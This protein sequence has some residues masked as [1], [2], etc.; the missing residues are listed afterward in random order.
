MQ[1]ASRLEALVL[2]MPRF[3]VGAAI[4]FSIALNL[5]NIIGRY[6]FRAPILWAEEVLVYLMVWSV[7]V[8]A[9]LVTWEGRHLKMD[10]LS[11]RIPP[12]F[13]GVVG[14]IG[15]AIFVAVCALGLLESWTVASL[16]SEQDNRSV[17]ADLPMVIPHSALVLGFA[18]MLLAVV[19]RFRSYVGNA[20]GSETEAATRQVTETFGIFEGAEEPERPQR[21]RAP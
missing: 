6:V 11:V 19:V 3:I 20:F 8:G 12:P 4:F 5:A 9:V 16:M 2:A 17:A 14:F 13:G 1:K 21:E 18:G 10:L 7:F 15:A